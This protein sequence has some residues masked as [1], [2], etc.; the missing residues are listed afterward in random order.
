MKNYPF[1][2]GLLVLILA[3]SCDLFRDSDDDD[4]V[5]ERCQQM[6]FIDDSLFDN[7]ESSTFSPTAITV[8]GDCLSLT[9]GASGC[10]GDTWSFDLVGRTYFPET[11]PP[12]IRRPLRL[13]LQNEEDCRAFFTRTVQFDI[14]EL[15]VPGE[16]AV[17][18][19]LVNSDLTVRYGY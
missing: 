18:I 6:A 15:R 16:T 7:G 12:Q 3:S 8:E 11:L 5:N 1:T 13:L 19:D 9:F 10:S 17:I 2:L 4:P 14:T